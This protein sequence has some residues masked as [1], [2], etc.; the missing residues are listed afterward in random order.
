MAKKG[1]F[2]LMAALCASLLNDA[3]Y[4][5]GD[6]DA[7]KQAFQACAQC[8]GP[9]PAAEANRQQ[10]VPRL[11]GQHAAYLLASLDAYA[12]GKRK[13]A[14]MQPIAAALSQQESE[15]IAAYLGQFELKQLPI[16]GTDEAPAA[17]ATIIDNCQVCHGVGGNSFVPDYPRLNGQNQAY[18]IE[19]LNSYKNGKRTNATMVYVVKDLSDQALDEIAAYYA[20]QQGGLTVIDK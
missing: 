10:P 1:F 14:E 8:H 12:S 19:A 2:L 6:P 11:G 16:P 9:V 3:V 13:H 15:D 17:I 4:A 18:L 5:A 20:G 7:G